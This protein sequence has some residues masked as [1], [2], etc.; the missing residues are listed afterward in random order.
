MEYKKNSEVE[1]EFEDLKE[2]L[3][4][5]EHQRWADWQ[6]FLFSVCEPYNTDDITEHG[7]II[8]PRAFV[9][10]WQKEIDTAYKDLTEKEKDSDREQVDRYLPLL[11]NFILSQ[12]KQDREAIR[13]WTEKK[14]YE[15]EEI[16][17]KKCCAILPDLL[18]FLNGLEGE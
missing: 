4:D 17:E 12:R 18:S 15:I 8:I 6:E 2:K 9:A 3:A 14:I 11:K 1:Q 7:Q 5:I 13:Q 10:C 16:D